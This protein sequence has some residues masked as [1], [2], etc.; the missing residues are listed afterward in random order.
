MAVSFLFYDL[1][2]SGVNPREDRVMQ[3]A[4]QRTD[5]QLKPIGEP[6]NYF[7][8]LTPDILPDPQAILITGITPQKT[9]SE[10][11]TEAEFLSLFHKEIATPGTI[12][13]GFNSVRFDDEFMRYMQYRNFRDPYEWSWKDNRSRWDMLDV[14]RMTRALR[15]DGIQWPFASDGT[16]TNRLELLSELNQL[17]HLSA[18]DALSDV[19][20]TIALA[21]LIRDKQPK[22]FDFLLE[23]RNKRAVAELVESDAPFI[24]SSGRYANEFQKT[25]A[26]YYLGKT[27]QAQTALVYDLRYNPEAYQD[28][29]AD[30]LVEAM[31][32]PMDERPFPIPFKQLKYNRC[33]A[34]APLGVLD[35]A[36]QKR[37]EIDLD[38]VKKH[39]AILK[40]LRPQL[41]DT[42]RQALTQLAEVRQQ[43]LVQDEVE[44]DSQL[45]EGFIPDEDKPIM[46]DVITATPEKLQPDN[47]RFKDERLQHLLPLYKARN[48][49]E[50]LTAD[51]HTAW[52]SFRHRRLVSG[53]EQ[54]RLHQFAEKL[55][56]QAKAPQ[57]TDQQRFL[58]EELQLYAESIAPI[59]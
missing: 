48:Y 51:E 21:R 57:I 2:T 9:R 50:S 39:T 4:A 7:I 30:E 15:P 25:A 12:F 55:Q 11:Y 1:E 34:V 52:E 45:Y 29:T 38:T 36:S 58:L 16:P 31:R 19:Q 59:E 18:H 22:L 53:G 8:K 28:V 40:K 49:Q 41:A 33:P 37:L 54:S 47:F 56:Q 32:T 24:Y 46:R 23:M 6:Y 5:D 17:E 43:T 42:F 3:F 13:T 27:D 14:V 26:A 10:G 35:E 44:V 20:A